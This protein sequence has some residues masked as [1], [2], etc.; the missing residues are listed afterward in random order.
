MRIESFVYIFE[1]DIDLDLRIEGLKRL[2]A[3][4]FTFLCDLAVLYIHEGL[5]M[6]ADQVIKEIIKKGKD[7]RSGDH[8]MIVEKYL[9]PYC[10]NKKWKECT[11]ITSLFLGK[12][13]NYF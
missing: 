1:K 3:I 4:R 7:L 12:N 9:H 2:S 8:D 10:T 11:E 5:H 6:E 13:I